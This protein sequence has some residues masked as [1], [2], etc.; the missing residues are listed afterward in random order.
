MIK[1]NCICANCSE[2][3]TE[4]ICP[5]CFRREIFTW[6]NEQELSK[7]KLRQLKGAVSEILDDTR[8]LSRSDISCI[9][10]HE[11]MSN[12]CSYCM[13]KD[14]MDILGEES[15]EEKE[16]LFNYKIHDFGIKRI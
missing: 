12:I 16:M 5:S 8:V 7:D 2:L 6:L 10:C 13:T 9:I 14:S 11:R 3:I 1:I 4:P 15:L